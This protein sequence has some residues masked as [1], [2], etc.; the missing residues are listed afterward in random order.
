MSEFYVTTASN[1]P[2]GAGHY[3]VKAADKTEARIKVTDALGNNWC[4]IYNKLND[5]HPN[6]RRV[7][8]GIIGDEKWI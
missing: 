5:V 2:V 6:D 4:F 3:V 7:C 1:H 8:H